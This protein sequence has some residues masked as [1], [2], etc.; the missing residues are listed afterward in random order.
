MAKP[1]EQKSSLISQLMSK[2]IAAESNLVILG[3]LALT[4]K[5][6]KGQARQTLLSAFQ[7]LQPRSAIS[8]PLWST[9]NKAMGYTLTTRI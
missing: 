5:A 2:S 3:K 9:K 1:E 4:L 8:R 6:I 7:G